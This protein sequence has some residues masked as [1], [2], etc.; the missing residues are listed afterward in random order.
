MPRRERPLDV[1]DDALLRFAADL[2]RLRE[3]AGGP[4]YRELAKRAH[5]SAGTLSEAAGGRK[6]P[7]MAVT[8]AFVRA[9]GVDSAEWQERW[10][11]L[12]AEMNPPGGGETPGESPPYVGLSSFEPQD[13]HRFFGRE[14][15]VEKIRSS[16]S[17]HRFLAVLGASGSG[18]SSLLR[19]GLLPLVRP[20]PAILLTPGAHPLQECAVQLAARL[21]VTPG[22]LLAELTEDPRN[23]GLAVRQLLAKEGRDG[24]LVLIV[25]QFEE[26]FTLCPGPA[27][28]ARFIDALVSAARE[29]GSRTRVVLGVRTD[30][31]TH[32]ARHPDLADV[33][34]RA[35]ILVGPMTAEELRQAITR[36]AAEM[37]YRVEGALVSRLIADATGQPGVLPLIS[38][39]LLETWRRRRGNTLTLA[40]YESTGGIDHAIAQT[41][42]AVYTALSEDQQAVA[43]QIFLR[44]TALGEGTEDTKRRVAGD[45]LTGTDDDGVLDELTRARLVTRNGDNVEIAHEA[46]IRSWP[47]L[48]G[49]LAEDR[50]GLR[51]HRQIT[52]AAGAWEAESRDDGALY[53]GTRLAVARDWA[54][55]KDPVLSAREREFL[56]AGVA[57]EARDQD[58]ARRRARR[59]R[60]LVA[61]LAVLLVVAGS[62]TVYAVA[63]GRMAAGQRD[64]ALSQKVAGDAVE[65]RAANPALSAQLALAAYRL[66]PTDE[67]RS[68]L[69]STFATPYATRVTGHT[70]RV[71]AVAVSPDGRLLATAGRD[72]TTRLWRIA[73][74]HRPQP[75]AVLT[76]HRENVNAAAFSP[77]GRLLATAGWD[78]T[79]R[80]WDTT[81]PRRPRHLAALGHADDVNAVAFSPDGRTL[82][83]A[84]TDT[85]VRLW[86]VAGHRLRATLAG[87]TAGV[88]GVAFSPDGRTLASASFDHAA[89][90]WDVTD[91]G[92]PGRP[93]MLTGH[94]DAVA[95]VAFSPDGRLLATASNDGTARLWDVAAGTSIVIRGHRDVA[96]SVA[97]S[98]DGRLLATAS[99]D[100]T[101]RLTDVGDPRHPRLVTT[102]TGHTGNAVSVAF[103]PDGHTL[104]TASDDYTAR[105]W[106]LPGPA[107]TVPSAA[108]YWIAFNPDG[109]TLATVGEDHAAR[110][111]EVTDPVHPRLRSVLTGHEDEIWGTAFSPDGRT[112]ATASNDGT[113]RLWD[114]TDAGRPAP[115]ATLT[116][117]KENVNA[118]AFSPDGR[119]L[120]SASLDHTVRLTDVSGPGRPRDLSF[121]T[122]DTEGVN[123]VAFSPDGRTV[124][125]AGWNRT[126]R[127]WDVTDLRRPAPLATLTGHTDG[128]NALAFSPDG[129]TLATAGYDDTARLWDVADPRRAAPL[130][131]LA[132]HTDNV[133]MV[134]FSPDGRT[135]A[136]AGSD[137][138]TRLWDL[139]DVRRPR[140]RSSLEAHTDRVSS[141]AF[142]PDGHTLAT[143][144]YDR[145]VL[146]WETDPAR[147]ATRLCR[148]THPAIT[149]AEWDQYFP[150]LAYRPPCP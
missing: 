81:D 75:L 136:T 32:C 34:Q 26:V 3:K 16:L 121:F 29:P 68:V 11:A 67:A 97:F 84:S 45:E 71:N 106:D 92:H 31:Y 104:A 93:R 28:Q 49:W 83:S 7:S 87:H 94:T 57:A 36:P 25:D 1:G 91:P 139:A 119:V 146:L 101:I 52:E 17:E 23:L 46:L 5:Y 8:L 41:S 126:A 44:L 130:T 124:A 122:G 76:G 89:G 90:L 142:S 129:R 118:V 37:D 64:I 13:A 80:L 40:G 27:E 138:V 18:K 103:T 86:D 9:C 133:S 149:T 127:L 61:L 128:I 55:A 125:T 113:A 99:L 131:T 112:L 14:R 48:R 58:A 116:G 72:A 102:L 6:L 30:F 144:G 143:G 10:I 62:A 150:G 85:T 73:D 56:A 145:T 141:V 88:V 137:R 120:A 109:R 65:L 2:R 42:E 123:A 43:R 140:E 53:R 66:S 4:S 35:Q 82:A 108:V 117:H 51:L 38:H 54:A 63:N 132:R 21:G 74:P 77:D 12:A 39:A 22:G 24:D 33:L 79:A 115:R 98:P 111:W 135:L 47:R 70:D 19:A 69:L 148:I 105:L 107:L 78:H 114:V 110:L 15:L 134:A 95:W 147:L 96:R 59:L 50:E 60:E 100:D 20:R